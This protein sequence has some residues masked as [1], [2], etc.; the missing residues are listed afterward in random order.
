[1]EKDTSYLKVKLTT[2]FEIACRQFSC[3]DLLVFA[4]LAL[5]KCRK[6]LAIMLSI[7]VPRR[8]FKVTH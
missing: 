8:Y 7:P 6:K 3:F 2:L 4:K 5:F 1:M